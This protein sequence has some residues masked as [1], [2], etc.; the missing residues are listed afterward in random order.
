MRFDYQSECHCSKTKYG[1]DD[2]RPELF[3]T[4]DYELVDRKL[5]YLAGHLADGNVEKFK[6]DVAD[7]TKYYVK[8]AAQE[9]MIK[10]CDKA[11]VRYARVPTGFETCSFC[12][13]LASRGFEYR[14]EMTAGSLHKFHKDC[15]CIVVPGARGRTKIDGYDPEGMHRRWESCEKAIG[16]SKQAKVEWDALDEAK[17]S[18]YLERADGNK[19]KAFRD[20]QLRRIRR[21]IKTR[22]WHWLYTGEAPK[23]DYS[24]QSRDSIG[25]FTKTGTYDREHLVLVPNKKGELVEPNEWRDIYVHD[26]LKD[27]GFRVKTRPAKALGKN[28]KELQGV[29]N[30]DIE[31]DGVLWEIKSPRGISDSSLS[32]IENAFEAAGNNFKNPYDYTTLKGIGDRSDSKRVVLN[33]RYKSFDV[34]DE[35]VDEKIKQ[36]EQSISDL[37]ELLDMT[38]GD[39]EYFEKKLQ[40]LEQRLRGLYQEKNT[41]QAAVET[42]DNQ[43]DDMLLSWLEQE[44]YSLKQYHDSL[45]RKIIK[46]VR[47]LQKDRIEVTF[48]DGEKVKALVRI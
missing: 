14:D 11:E 5:H 31:I 13:M 33:T 28:G 43:I 20:F 25:Q 29:S 44:V 38:T 10:N 40:E 19:S 41:T 27:S 12:F 32:F 15:D 3:D 45:V 6:S 37:T 23:I 30:P 18:E 9:N 26:A 46:E 34:S 21:E 39:A 2:V 17:K 7:V 48:Q 22:D 16:G 4:T 35:A 24:L 42:T 36:H 8:R 47:V 1:W